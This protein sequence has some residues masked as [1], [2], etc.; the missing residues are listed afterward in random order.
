MQYIV[1][2]GHP[3]DLIEIKRNIGK[4][5]MY[6]VIGNYKIEL[7]SI[8]FIGH[9]NFKVYCKFPINKSD[10]NILIDILNIMLRT[11]EIVSYSI[12]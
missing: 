7:Q 3:G 9:N 11:K 5:R 12:L 1:F 4:N 10:V 2:K 6:L 8:K